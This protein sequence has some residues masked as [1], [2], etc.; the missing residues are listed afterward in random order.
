MNLLNLTV[1]ILSKRR[2]RG[3][4]VILNI[5]TRALKPMDSPVSLPEFYKKLVETNFSIFLLYVL[6][7]R[8]VIV[9]E[10]INVFEIF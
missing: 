8:I 2:D 9:K 5:I 6:C 7:G 1:I 10:I 4:L 3:T